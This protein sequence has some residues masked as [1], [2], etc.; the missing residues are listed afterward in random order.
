K[1]A[2]PAA[3][4]ERP[5]WPHR[6]LSCVSC[7]NPETDRP[8]LQ[9]VNMATGG[10]SRVISNNIGRHGRARARRKT[11]VNALVLAAIHVFPSCRSKTWM[12]GS[13]DKFTQSAH[14]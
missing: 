7:C 1:Q 13:A 5:V 8:S 2:V 3:L 10:A 9:H 14:A 4:A 11:G 6:R 12:P